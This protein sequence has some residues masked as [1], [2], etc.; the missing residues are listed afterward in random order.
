[1]R[2]AF[3]GVFQQMREGH[4]RRLGLRVQGNGKSTE[5]TASQGYPQ[6]QPEGAHVAAESLRQGLEKPLERQEAAL[7]LARF[8]N[9]SV[10]ASDQAFQIAPRFRFGGEGRDFGQVRRRPLVEEME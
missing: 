2:D 10:S 1:L 8:V 6:R 5:G 4:E 9:L 7:A 3:S